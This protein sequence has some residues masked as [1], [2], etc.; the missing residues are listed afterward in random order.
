MQKKTG[1]HAVLGHLANPELRL[2]SPHNAVGV[3]AKLEGWLTYLSV[4]TAG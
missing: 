1:E 4:E 3:I 2:F